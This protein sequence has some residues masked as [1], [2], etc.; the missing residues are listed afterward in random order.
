MSDYFAYPG[1]REWWATRKHWLTD[2]FRAVVEAIIA[3]NPATDMIPRDWPDDLVAAF[4]SDNWEITTAQ[5]NFEIVK[6]ATG[7]RV[8]DTFGWIC[9][10]ANSGRAFGFAQEGASAAVFTDH[11]WPN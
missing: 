1:V 8:H 10:R 4:A 3:Q 2:E 7:F 9:K 11:S 6:D 5:A